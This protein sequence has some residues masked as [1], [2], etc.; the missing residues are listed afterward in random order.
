M[1]KAGRLRDSAVRRARA[2]ID[3]RLARIR[4]TSRPRAVAR[5]LG[6]RPPGWVG[7]IAE[8]LRH[9]PM[10]STRG[11]RYRITE[12]RPFAEVTSSLLGVEIG[13]TT[14]EIGRVHGHGPI[15]LVHVVQPDRLGQNI[16]LVLG[17]RTLR[18]GQRI[19]LQGP[20]L[21]TFAG[22]PVGARGLGVGL[23]SDLFERGEQR[24]ISYTLEAKVTTR[25]LAYWFPH[26]AP[27]IGK[28][29]GSMSGDSV[30]RVVLGAVPVVSIGLA[31]QSAVKAVRLWRRP[32]VTR[33]DKQLAVGHVLADSV[34][35]VFPLAGTLA[36]VVL[37]AGSAAVTYARLRGQRLAAT[38]QSDRQ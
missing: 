29:M 24:A 15:E 18:H 5:L 8:T 38:A 25:T 30:S 7:Q 19:E 20:A 9:H 27:V 13:L 23:T 12:E 6:R 4:P 2:R 11:Q 26:L 22:L 17:R 10:P 31:V 34:R 21:N 37:V 14:S 16:E 28:A 1:A 3:R 32:D 36:N 33:A 35:V